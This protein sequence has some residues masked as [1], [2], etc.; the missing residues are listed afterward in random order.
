MSFKKEKLVVE[1]FCEIC[2]ETIIS[3]FN[4]NCIDCC[5]HDLF[6]RYSLKDEN[7]FFKVSNCSSCGYYEPE[8][9]TNSEIV[10]ILNNDK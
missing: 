4:R 3:S 1:Y 2:K 7:S 9:L 5:I 10:E 6:F 8:I